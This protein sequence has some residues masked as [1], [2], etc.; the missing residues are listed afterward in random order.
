MKLS[1]RRFPFTEGD[2]F[3][4]WAIGDIHK[5]SANCDKEALAETISRVEADPSAL[6]IHMGDGHEWITPA[7]PRWDAE[8]VDEEFITLNQLGN[9]RAAAIRDAVAT[10]EPVKEKCI[11]WHDGN[12]EH[13]YDQHNDS[14]V[15]LEAVRRLGIDEDIYSPGS[16]LTQLVFEDKSRHV[17]SLVVY[18]DHGYQAG[19]KD[20]AKLNTMRELPSYIRADIYLRGHSHSLFVSPIDWLEPNANHTEVKA[21]HGYVSHTGSYLRTYQQNATG[22]GELAAYPPT[23][24]GSPR[25]ILHPSRSGCRIEAMT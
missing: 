7:D 21:H 2:T 17:C 6:Y 19:R 8:A 23:T 1:K 12:H 3:T 13:R 22:Y 18:S 16:A 24:I 9:I 10:W 4:L 25:F 15:T 11:L 20:G 5:G 14:H